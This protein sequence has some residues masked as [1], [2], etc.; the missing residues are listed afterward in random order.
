MLDVDLHG[1][2]NNTVYWQAVEHVLPAT[3]VDTRAPMRAELDYRHPIDLGKDV[4]LIA[5]DDG[6][7][8]AIGFVAADAVRAVARLGPLP[9]T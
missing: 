1:H 4:D 7:R 3:G 6:G 9:S 5:F 2:V 8:T